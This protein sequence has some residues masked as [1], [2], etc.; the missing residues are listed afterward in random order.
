M[1]NT[2]RNCTRT[3]NI[4]CGLDKTTNAQIQNKK[5]VKLVAFSGE[6]TESLL[7]AVFI[8]FKKNMEFDARIMMDY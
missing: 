5:K 7:W 4:S 3:G 1:T 2:G 6:L 8:W